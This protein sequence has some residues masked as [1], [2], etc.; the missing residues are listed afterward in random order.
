[1]YALTPPRFY[2]KSTLLDQGRRN[3]RFSI[4]PS[5]IGRFCSGVAASRKGIP[6]GWRLPKVLPED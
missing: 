2:R 1:V 4:D 6:P 3:Q 5:V